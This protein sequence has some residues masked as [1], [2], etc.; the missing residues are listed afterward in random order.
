MILRSVGVVRNKGG[1]TQRIE[2]Y[3]PFSEGLDGVEEMESLWVLYWMHRLSEADRK[4][5]RVHPRGDPANPMR[6]V[7]ATHSPARPN[8]IGLTRVHVVHREG[9]TLIVEGLDALDGSPVLDLKSA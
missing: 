7:F 9:N 6:G 5:L 8:P 2:I 4:I 1:S 3:E